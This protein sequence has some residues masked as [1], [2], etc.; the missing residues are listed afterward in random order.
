MK[1]KILRTL[2]M[3]PLTFLGLTGCVNSENSAK[4]VSSNDKTVN[5]MENIQHSTVEFSRETNSTARENLTLFGLN[6]FQQSIDVENIMISPISI[7]NALSMTSN[8]AVGETLTQ[9]EKT[10]GGSNI[11]L[12]AFLKEYNS[13]ISSSSANTLNLANSIWFKD[14]ERLEVN[15]NFLQTNKDFF[16]ADIFKTQFDDESLIDINNWVSVN[17]AGMIDSIIDEVP[18]NAIMYLINAISFDAEWENIYR[19][20]DIFE[21]DFFNLDGSV[22]QVEF[23]KSEEQRVIELKSAVGFIKPYKNNEFSFVGLIPN[24]GVS[25]SQLADELVDLNMSEMITSAKNEPVDVILPKFNV[26][27]SSQLSDILVYLGIEQ[28][29]DSSNADFSDLAI[30][31]GNIFIGDVLHKTYINVDEKGTQAGAATAV[32]MLMRMSMGMPNREIRLNSPFIY[33]IV[34]NTRNFPI[35]LG[36]INYL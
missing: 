21:G 36:N 20:V 30:G 25:I 12:S 33:M 15:Q 1:R 9:M 24:A 29:F 17:T 6:L 11:E 26:E 7:I 2:L 18:K 5:L 27:Y 28:A 19:D 35:F 13:Q 14:S 4:F 8:G 23:M 31:D 16:D 32:E 10:L 22:S 34:D 3:L